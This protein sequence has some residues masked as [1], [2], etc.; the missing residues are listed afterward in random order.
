MEWCYH[1][2]LEVD[3][4]VEKHGTRCREK[5]LHGRSSAA[6]ASIHRYLLPNSL[7][8]F[9]SR[10][11]SAVSK[12]GTLWQIRTRFARVPGPQ[13]HSLQQQKQLKLKR[14]CKTTH[15]ALLHAPQC[16]SAKPPTPTRTRWQ[17]KLQHTY[18]QPFAVLTALRREE[19]TRGQK[20][21]TH[22]EG[23]K[24]ERNTDLRR[25]AA[26]PHAC[27]RPIHSPEK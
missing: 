9:G 19:E 5:M 26:A 22:A 16:P 18:P 21:Q 3:R 8:L 1:V 13:H 27:I 17:V 15:D 23:E 14:C 25:G 20:G 6:C 4:G 10:A 12:N 11:V 24:K 2:L 7:P